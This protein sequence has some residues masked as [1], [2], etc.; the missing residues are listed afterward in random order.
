MRLPFVTRARYNRDL[1][2]ERAETRRVKQVKD[3]FWQQR[4]AAQEL[5]DQRL[6]AIEQLRDAK[7]DAPL[8]Y[9]APSPEVVRLRQQLNLSEKARRALDAD[10]SELIGINVQLTREVRELREAAVEGAAS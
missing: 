3:E 10:R 9:P 8:N 1:A 6:A 5:A 7:P 2:A 4:D